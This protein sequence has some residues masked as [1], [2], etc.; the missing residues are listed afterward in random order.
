MT[1]SGYGDI[2]GDSLF[3]LSYDHLACLLTV[4]MIPFESDMMTGLV[5][6]MPNIKKCVQ[7]V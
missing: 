6:Y 4:D 3:L 5:K 7:H 2:H 1:G